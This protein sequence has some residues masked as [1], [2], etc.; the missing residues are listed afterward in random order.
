MT[1]PS[2]PPAPIRFFSG[3]AGGF[4]DL[5]IN[6]WLAL[7]NALAAQ[8]FNAVNNTAPEGRFSIA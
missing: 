4:G 3:L 6:Q 8:I 5:L 1:P 2:K 7:D